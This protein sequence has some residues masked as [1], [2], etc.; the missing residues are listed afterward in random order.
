MFRVNLDLMPLSDS[1][2][3]AEY[4]DTIAIVQEVLPLPR[5]YTAV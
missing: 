1:D 5:I 3:E 4:T 2:F